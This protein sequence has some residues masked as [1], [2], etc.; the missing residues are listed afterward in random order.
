VQSDNIAVLGVSKHYAILKHAT[1]E[2]IDQ[3]KG[4]VCQLAWP[5]NAR[6]EVEQLWSLS[7]PW[8]AD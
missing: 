8:A 6:Q 5:M 3:L 7:E 1:F 4:G 2:P